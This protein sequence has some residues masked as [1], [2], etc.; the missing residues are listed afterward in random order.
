[1]GRA[2]LS[3]GGN[4]EPER[5]LA[6]AID[7][8][9]ARFPGALVSRVYRTRAVGFEGADFLNAGA[10]IDSDLD[11]Y[12]LDAWL[13]ALEDAHGRERGGPRFGDRTLDLDLVLYDDLVLDGACRSGPN[14]G[15]APRLPRPELR[16]AF[17]LR[18]L[19]EIAPEIVEPLS[20]RTLAEL[21]AESPER[22]VPM[23]P[24]ALAGVA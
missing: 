6:A 5:H 8:L 4:L 15:Q 23:T 19:A 17:V 11:A 10:V 20:G 3:L 22:D 1:M 7:A 24:V 9:R 14:Q 21:W 12:A 16:H 18:P 2:C 13:H